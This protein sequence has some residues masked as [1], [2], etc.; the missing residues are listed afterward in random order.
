MNYEPLILLTYN[1]NPQSTVSA[2]LALL[3][4][5]ARRITHFLHNNYALGHHCWCI[6]AC[7]LLQR[8]VGVAGASVAD[9]IL[10][11]TLRVVY[12]R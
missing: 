10:E 6:F 12:G 1:S 8:G 3:N 9:Y 5:R 2:R 11:A 7:E 4:L